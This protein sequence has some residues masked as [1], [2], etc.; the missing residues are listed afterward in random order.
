[1]QV[2]QISCYITDGTP[3]NIENP[4]FIQPLTSLQFDNPVILLNDARLPHT[5]YNNYKLSLGSNGKLNDN[6]ENKSEIINY[7]GKKYLGFNL[8]SNR[9]M[10]STNDL[11]VNSF[12]VSSYIELDPNDQVRDFTTLDPIEKQSYHCFK[13]P[14][15]FLVECEITYLEDIPAENSINTQ[16]KSSP[17]GP[18]LPPDSFTVPQYTFRQNTY[19]TPFRPVIINGARPP[20]VYS[21]DPPLP[22]G[23]IFDVDTGT[24]RGTP[25]EQ[26]DR[27]KHTVS[28]DEEDVNLY[29]K[30]FYISVSPP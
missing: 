10:P 16:V 12:V 7:N 17:T 24:I 15:G 4:L 29:K 3:A 11:P 13:G 1:M 9:K 26:Q 28:I 6:E 27:V 19:Q 2:N 23:L 22:P 30:Q 18:Y 21:V 5:D 14:G 20:Y 8:S 25:T